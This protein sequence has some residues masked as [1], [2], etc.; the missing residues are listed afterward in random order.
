[1]PQRLRGAEEEGERVGFRDL[2]MGGFWVGGFLVPPFDVVSF[3]MVAEATMPVMVS[4]EA[5][6]LKILQ[7]LNPTLSSP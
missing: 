6:I 7:S 5:P 1:L 3:L 2:G 4:S